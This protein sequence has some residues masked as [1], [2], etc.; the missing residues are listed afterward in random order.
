MF[1]IMGFNT[2]L[3]SPVY[4]SALLFPKNPKCIFQLGRTVRICKIHLLE[5]G[6][7]SPPLPRPLYSCFTLQPASLLPT[8]EVPPCSTFPF[9]SSMS[10]LLIYHM[11]H[12]IYLLFIVSVSCWSVS[13]TRAE[14]FTLFND[15]FPAS[16]IAFDV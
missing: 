2:S 14:S 9:F 13:I 10:H 12:S 7:W 16:R 11:N 5:R 1:A 6:S 15:V 3:P 4:P 8:T